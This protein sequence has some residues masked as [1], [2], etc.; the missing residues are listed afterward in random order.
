M[1]NYEKDKEKIEWRRAMTMELP[2]NTFAW[3]KKECAAMGYDP[4]IHEKQET[5]RTI[6]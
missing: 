1:T 2:Q 3:L 5:K 6:N 4:T